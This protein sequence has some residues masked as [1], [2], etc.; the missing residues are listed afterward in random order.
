MTFSSYGLK[1]ISPQILDHSVVVLHGIRQ[2]RDDIQSPFA[3]ALVATAG[4]D[5]TIYTFGYD[6]TQHLDSSGSKLARELKDLP[7]GRIDLV[8][9]SMGGLVA[10][11]AATDGPDVEVHTIVTLATPNRGALS[12]AQLTNLGQFTK[13][14]LNNLISPLAPRTNGVNDLTRVPELMRNRREQ[15]EQNKMSPAAR[16]A[17]IPA[18]YYNVNRSSFTF[19]PSIQMNAV[20]AAIAALNLRKRLI[21]MEK[22]HDGIVTEKS[23][24]IT[25]QDTHEWAEFHLSVP[26]PNDEPSRC[27]AVIPACSD[28]DHCS[29]VS[30]PQESDKVAELVWILLQEPDWQEL[31]N[32]RSPHYNRIRIDLH[33]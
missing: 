10:R 33:P 27:H 22:S 11:M 25:R 12:N 26:G 2:T 23:N 3:D 14:V 8:G 15:M 17:S 5:A 7:D 32:P 1:R 6:H 13:G 19:G 30:D 31:K 9:Y 28:N 29:V 4:T 21:E 18:L 20:Q 16:Y 24:E